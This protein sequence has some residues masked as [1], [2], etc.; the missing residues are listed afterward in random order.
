MIVLLNHAVQLDPAHWPNP[1]EYVPDRFLE[2]Y[3]PK[4][5]RYA[6]RPFSRGPRACAGQELAMDELRI[7]L[8]LTARWLDFETVLGKVPTESKITV[9]DWET[10]VGDLAFQQLKMSAAP[11]SEMRMR[12][13]KS[14]RS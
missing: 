8:L 7:M 6:W 3:E 2:S 5:D 10:R 1:T 11:R 4:H 13:R 14:G 12:V 9:T